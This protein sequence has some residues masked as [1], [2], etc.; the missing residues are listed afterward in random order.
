MHDRL[1]QRAGFGG[2]C[3]EDGIEV[4][5]IGGEGGTAFAGWAKVFPEGIEQLLFIVAVAV[6]PGAEAGFHGGNLGLGGDEFV[7]LDDA[8]DIGVF[9]FTDLAALQ[10]QF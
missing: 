5:G 9:S 2:A 8:G 10:R 3:G 1:G 6:P 4:S 7:E